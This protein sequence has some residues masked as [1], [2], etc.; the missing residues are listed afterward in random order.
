MYYAV[1]TIG[2]NG[3]AFQSSSL[4]KQDR[5]SVD[6]QNLKQLSVQL[7]KADRELVLA[8]VLTDWLKMR[9]AV[10]ICHNLMRC[11]MLNMQTNFFFLRSGFKFLIF[12]AQIITESNSM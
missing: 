2:F 1:G 5:K 9:L 8:L 6:G 11:Q 10:K 7:H 12:V 3:N 4:T